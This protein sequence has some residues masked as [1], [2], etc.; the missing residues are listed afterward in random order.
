M[1][2]VRA[3]AQ[4]LGLVVLL[5]PAAARADTITLTATGQGSCG[6][7]SGCNNVNP[8]SITIAFAGSFASQLFN[9]WFAFNIPSAS[10]SVVAAR[11]NIPNDPSTS[12]GLGYYLYIEPGVV[13]LS[14][15]SIGTPVASGILILPLGIISIDLNSAG[16]ALLNAGQGSLVYFAGFVPG[17][18]P[19]KGI[20]FT[21]GGSPAATLNLTTVPGATP[22]PE[23]S[24]L[25]LLGTG[26]IGLAGMLRRKLKH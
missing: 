2:N 12:A 22:V 18:I 23:P 25:L 6:T 5:S 1:R 8:S 14:N 26:V 17:A 7:L 16:V 13:T 9:N 11:I 10:G 24:S 3:V 20:G 19:N 15:I 4:T 21:V